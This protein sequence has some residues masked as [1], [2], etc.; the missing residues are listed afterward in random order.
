MASTDVQETKHITQEWTS[1]EFRGKF[2]PPEVQVS[3][4]HGR[5]PLI[6]QAGR[7]NHQPSVFVSCTFWVI[8]SKLN[9]PGSPANLAPKRPRSNRLNCCLAL[10]PHNTCAT[11]LNSG[12][13]LGICS[14]HWVILAYRT[15]LRLL[16]RPQNTSQLGSFPR[17]IHA[18]RKEK[19]T[20]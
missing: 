15:C 4:W 19:W 6:Q 16:L 12:S 13:A 9:D 2:E 1:F 8:C 3:K 5:E 18:D 17:A 14:P 10:G 7:V 20:N 11:F